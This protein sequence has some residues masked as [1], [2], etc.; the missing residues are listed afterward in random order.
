MAKIVVVGSLN[1]DLIGVTPRLPLGGETILGTRYLE[2]PG[3][4]GANQAYAAAKLGGDVVMLGRVGSDEHG[5]RMRANLEAVRCDIRGVRS[6][7]GNSG[8]AMILVAESGQN[9]IVVIPG[10]NL[11]YT[12]EDFTADESY[13]SGAGW[14]LLQREIP[15]DT[16]IA[17]ADAA[18]RSG[19]QVVL[20][21]APVPQNVPLELLRNVDVLTPNE[22]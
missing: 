4:K 12:R 21:P 20:D 19:A 7:Q 3:G 11:R 18:R 2:E 22:T 6:I 8:I 10:A 1:L 13:L 17:A 15:P 14:V 5:R 9:S 16:V